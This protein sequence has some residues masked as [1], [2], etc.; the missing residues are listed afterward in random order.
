[1]GRIGLV[2]LTPFYKGDNF[3]HPACLHAHKTPSENLSFFLEY[4]PFFRM[5][6]IILT[7]L[8]LLKVVPFPIN[9]YRLCLRTILMFGIAPEA[10]YER[11][12]TGP[13]LLIF[14]GLVNVITK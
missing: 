11:S 7:A 6:T 10:V 3:F 8:A 1:M 4:R 5:D 13:M 12:W 2:D 9:N 14:H